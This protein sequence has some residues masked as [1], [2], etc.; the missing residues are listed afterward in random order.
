MTNLILCQCYDESVLI[1]LILVDETIV[2][3]KL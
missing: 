1:V 3:I 2:S